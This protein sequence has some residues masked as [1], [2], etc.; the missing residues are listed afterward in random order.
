MM[1]NINQELTAGVVKGLLESDLLSEN[2]AKMRN[3]R[4]AIIEDRNYSVHEWFHEY[5]KSEDIGKLVINLLMNKGNSIPQS[6]KDF[7]QFHHEKGTIDSSTY[8]SI[9][10]HMV[11]T[12]NYELVGYMDINAVYKYLKRMIDDIDVD[13][14]ISCIDNIC[15][16]TNSL[17]KDYIYL[18]LRKSVSRH[19]YFESR[20]KLR[21]TLI[22]LVRK[23]SY[24]NR[25]AVYSAVYTSHVTD[26]DKSLIRYSDFIM[27]YDGTWFRSTIDI[28]SI[29]DYIV[30]YN[31]VSDHKYVK[32]MDDR[33]TNHLESYIKYIKRDK[34]TYEENLRHLKQLLI[35]SLSRNPDNIKFLYT[36]IEISNTNDKLNIMLP[37]DHHVE[38]LDIAIKMTDPSVHNSILMQYVERGSDIRKVI[39]YIGMIANNE[40]IYTFITKITPDRLAILANENPQ[41]YSRANV[42]LIDVIM[43]NTH[44]FTTGMMDTIRLAFIKSGKLYNTLNATERAELYFKSNDITAICSKFPEIVK[45]TDGISFADVSIMYK[46]NPDVIHHVDPSLLSSTTMIHH[47]RTNGFTEIRNIQWFGF[48]NIMGIHDY[49][50]LL[51]IGKGIGHLLDFSNV[52]YRNAIL[53]K[54][55]N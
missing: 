25:D 8:S 9:V 23:V 51:K 1:T 14:I 38:E 50:G 52:G 20:D 30:R 3:I 49:V 41:V 27:H 2:T 22:N 21:D 36:V 24:I 43:S 48:E 12:K 4:V 44:K 34:Q 28:N 31:F 39:P 46:M 55:L 5:V 47:I 16:V 19:W 35:K 18:Y 29:I 15:T 54:L 26:M 42:T 13:D 17:P 10:L 6:A 32:P 11:Y 45:Y 7:I 53:Q 40:N 33:L 37:K